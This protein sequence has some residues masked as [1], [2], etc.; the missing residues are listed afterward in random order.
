MPCRSQLDGTTP[1]ALLNYRPLGPL[2]YI[3]GDYDAGGGMRLK[4]YG[5]AARA[6]LALLYILGG[7]LLL[8]TQ[9]YNARRGRA[10]GQRHRCLPRAVEPQHRHL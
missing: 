10:A 6:A 4:R 2:Y 7:H 8:V 5:T 1:A 9:L 3:H